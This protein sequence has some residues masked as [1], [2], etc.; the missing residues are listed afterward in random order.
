MT[1]TTLCGKAAGLL[2]VAL[3]ALPALAADPLELDKTIKLQGPVN[4]RLDHLALD[5]KRDRLY[6][7]NNGNNTLDIVDLKAGKVLKSIP[8]QTEIQ[9]VLYVPALDRVFATCA[10]GSCNVFDGDSGKLLKAFKI[11]EADN[12]GF[13]PRKGLVYV[14]QKDKKLAVIDAKALEPKGEIALPSFGASFVF[15]K[16]RPRMYVN[17]PGPR[18]VVVIDTD[19]REVLKKHTVDEAGNNPLVLDEANKRLYVGCRKEPRLL[20]L[21]SETGKEV[22]KVIIPNDVDD[23]FLDA[24]RKRIY[25]SCGEGVLV[26]LRQTAT[27]K[28]EVMAKIPTLK[29]A[30]TCLFDAA[31]DRLFVPVPRAMGQDAPEIR[32]YRAVQ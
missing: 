17:T 25:L 32:V 31:S 15:E 12:V 14:T 19:K 21:D 7:A 23:I 6:I 10:T 26:V 16:D 29:Q 2:F 9:G 3:L 5:A 27:D 18:Q 20:I 4:K 8:E 13:D 28:Y 11:P 30:R 24:K 1:R 22:G